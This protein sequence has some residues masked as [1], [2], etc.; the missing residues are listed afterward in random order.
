M[1]AAILAVRIRSLLHGMQYC[2]P[3]W[4]VLPQVGVAGKAKIAASSTNAPSFRL[5]LHVALLPISWS[6]VDVPRPAGRRD[7]DRLT[8]AEPRTPMLFGY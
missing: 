4:A 7:A 3:G 1:R 2:G 8:S 6:H 5:S